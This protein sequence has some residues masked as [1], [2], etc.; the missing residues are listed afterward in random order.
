MAPSCLIVVD[1]QKGFVN[2]A[3]AA[4]PAKVEALQRRFDLVAATRFV[5]PPGSAF[6]R[7]MDWTRFAPGSAEAELAWTPRADAPIFEKSDYSAL[8]GR[9]RA[10][11]G[12]RGVATVHLAGIAT[13]NCVLKTAVDL[14]E[15]G[16]RPVVLEDC[17]A[18]HGGPDCHAAGL[19]LLRRFIGAGQLAAGA[20]A[21]VA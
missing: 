17:C 9:L 3:T 10:W 20:A 12:D 2:A 8:D 13:D 21:P 19:L 6:R 16:W 1:V 5:N 4:I 7:L 11:L 18:S 14:F 15:A